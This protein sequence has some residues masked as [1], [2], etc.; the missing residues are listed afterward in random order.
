MLRR[1]SIGIVTPSSFLC[2]DAK[3]AFKLLLCFSSI[4]WLCLIFVVFI[5]I[6]LVISISVTISIIVVGG[7]VGVMFVFI[8]II[9]AL[10]VTWVSCRNLFRVLSTWSGSCRG[11]GNA[12]IYIWQRFSGKTL[13]QRGQKIFASNFFGGRGIVVRSLRLRCWRSFTQL[14]W[15]DDSWNNIRLQAPIPFTHRP[16]KKKREVH[17]PFMTLWFGLF[18]V[19]GSLTVQVF[20]DF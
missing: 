3:L 17:V 20:A 12:M 4:V 19:S 1:R 11:G 18:L 7:G 9:V 5:A 16:Q 6:V 8:L 10:W 15:F 14:L 2:M 13:F